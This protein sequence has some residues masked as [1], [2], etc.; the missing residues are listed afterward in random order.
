MSVREVDGET[1]R[2]GYSTG[3][4]AAREHAL[5]SVENPDGSHRLFTYDARG[6]LETAATDGNAERVTFGYGS[7]GAVSAT[8][9]AGHASRY[10]FDH[11]GLPVGYEDALG[12]R[13]PSPSTP[14]STHPGHRRGGAELHL[15]VR[16][17][18]HPDSA[19]RPAAAGHDL[20]V[21]QRLQP[22][23]SV[24]DAGGRVRYGYDD[25][26]NLTSVTYADGRVEH[27]T[28][29]PAATPTTRPTAAAS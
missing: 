14:A 13:T 9:A 21:H 28:P 19:A 20:D 22:V 1:T 29:T 24:T 4:G 3:A 18:R 2:Y 5:L 16:R 27:I 15:P 25:R 23:A 12:H 7:P 11:R 10:F 8:D 6:R 26:G 17:P